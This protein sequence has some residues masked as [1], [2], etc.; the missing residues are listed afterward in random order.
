LI[1]NPS[2]AQTETPD[3]KTTFL[4]RVWI[5]Y[6]LLIVAGI[7]V[8][9]KIIHIQ[10]VQGSELLEKSEKATIKYGAIEP[11]R[12]N[13]LA[14][15][16]A[17]LATS[18]P[19]Y[20]FRMDVA[21]KN[22][23]DSIFDTRVDSLSRG[24]S[25]L[26]RD[27]SSSDYKKLLTSER[28]KKNRYLLIK[29]N[30]DYNTVARLKQLPLLK[31]GQN[32]GGLI[33]VQKSSR[34]MP[35]GLL[36]RRTIGYEIKE[37]NLFVG[38][39][40]AYRNELQG[41]TG[42][43]W[44]QRISGGEWIPLNDNDRIEPRNG[45]DIVTTIDIHLQ[46]V[47]EN[48]LM[49]HLI[50]HNAEQ[51]CVILMEV[52]TGAIR[53]IANLQRLPDGTY[54]E[55]YN[56]AI[57]ESIEP[58]STFKLASIMATIE[59]G[60]I[61]INDT[62]TVGRGS[63]NY[64]GKDMTD[65]HAMPRER[66]SV[67]E[68][69]ELSSNVGI[70]RIVH[71]AYKNSPEKFIERLYSFS[72]N[73]PL[74][75]EIQGEGKPGIKSTDQKNWSKLSLPW[76]SIGYE[77]TITPLQT[78]TF[79]NAVANGGKM[80][81]PMFVA[82]IRETGKHSKLFEPVVINKKIASTETLAKARILL[83]GVVKKGTAR[84]PFLNSAYT[85]AGKTGTAQIAKGGRYN[86]RNYNASFVGYFPADE[87][88]YSCIVV[89]NNPA[90]G[91]IYGSSVAAPVFREL[92]DKI[93][94]TNLSLRDESESQNDTLTHEEANLLVSV[95]YIRAARYSD[96]EVIKD[97]FDF[98]TDTASREADWVSVTGTGNQVKTQPR[99]FIE[100][101][102]PDVMGM[103]ARDA[104]YMLEKYGLRVKIEGCGKV[105]KQSIQ[106]GS[107]VAKGGEITLKLSN[108]W[109]I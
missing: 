55:R 109:I 91:T 14:Y 100:N 81:K 102:V 2:P 1:D 37:E 78:L 90:G 77:L 35:Y 12:G 45:K 82:E 43:M 44:L 41:V 46:D 64:Y 89:V 61:D 6:F 94:A 95:P 22:I 23:P 50:N 107:R 10:S 16:G 92:A 59:D 31:L 13:V 19:I 27:K 97:Y 29:R 69:F 49:N 51:G 104:I 56:Y 80:M 93:Y 105:K 34:K 66:L 7:A 17:L 86:K 99:R 53:A 88:A 101:L 85:V 58:G 71:D 60:L 54:D 106:P 28:H 83:E 24:L 33:L 108:A 42:R 103:T 87:P 48:A 84:I 62:V 75:I 25:N 11:V 52:K 76:M 67:L 18:V 57:A 8:L 20:D 47:A 15:D 70:S 98:D 68:A 96:I 39:E 65:V 3:P 73:K 21:S 72:L 4:R 74:G 30:V 5:V 32:K 38:L 79:Y 9:G 36:A 40:G 63:L 26:F